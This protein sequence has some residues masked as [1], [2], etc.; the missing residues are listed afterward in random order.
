MS[1]YIKP[2][3]IKQNHDTRATKNTIAQE[4]KGQ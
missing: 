2:Q 3:Q 1:K 4:T